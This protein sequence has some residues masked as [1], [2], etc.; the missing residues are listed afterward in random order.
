M[1][2]LCR[3]V[4]EAEHAEHPTYSLKCLE[5]GFCELRVDGVLGTSPKQGSAN[6]GAPAFSCVCPLLL[7][8][9]GAYK[10]H[11]YQEGRH[12]R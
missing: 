1:E 7:D 6:H 2:R 5:G 12:H 3:L 11:H 8:L 10:P 4:L 9:A